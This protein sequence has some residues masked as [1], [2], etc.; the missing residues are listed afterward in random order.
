MLANRVKETT[1]TTG[2][3][4]FTTTGAVTDGK[5]FTF[6]EKYGLD[7]RFSYWAIND[8]DDE[9]EAGE[10]YMSDSTTLVRETVS[11][12]HL[13]TTATVNFTAA[14][15]LQSN[16]NEATVLNAMVGSPSNAFTASYVRPI[17]AITMVAD[18]I[19]LA[20]LEI[21]YKVTISKLGLNLRT[22]DAGSVARLGIYERS[23]DGTTY[24]LL[25]EGSGTLDTGATTGYKTTSLTSS[26]TL[27]P[28]MYF[29]GVISDGVPALYGPSTNI[30][31]YIQILG[32]YTANNEPYSKIWKDITSGW[33]AM[34]D[35]VTAPSLGSGSMPIPSV[36]I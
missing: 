36:E 11:D 12:N 33:S 9:M 28:G 34:P 2:T 7:R 31:E 24:N 5:F 35:P 26:L 30:P 22:V 14:P 6:Y 19:T 8:T 27:Y 13:G 23:A 17:T 16:A 29:L 21:K 10:G 18:R 32:M 3:D 15:T 4:S 25:R 1:S 20:P